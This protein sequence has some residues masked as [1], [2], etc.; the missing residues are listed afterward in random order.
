MTIQHMV[1]VN[2]MAFYCVLWSPSAS[3]QAP[4]FQFPTKKKPLNLEIK[5]EATQK[6]HVQLQ[7]KCNGQGNS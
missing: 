7:F 3:S 6:V 4:V 1:I 5:D 2:I